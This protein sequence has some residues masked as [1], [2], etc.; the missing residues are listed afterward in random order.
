MEAIRACDT[1]LLLDFRNDAATEQAVVSV[2]VTIYNLASYID[3][4]LNSVLN[5]TFAPIELIVVD[6]CSTDGASV[7]TTLKWMISNRN[8]FCRCVLVQHKHNEGLAQAR[9]TGY[10]FSHSS[11]LFTLDV[12]N[13]IKPLCIETLYSAL[14]GSIFGMAFS[15][16]EIFGDEDGIGTA[17]S[18]DPKRLSKGNYIDAMALIARWA[19]DLVGGYTH[20]EGG[21]EDYDFWCKFVDNDIQGIFVPEMLCRYRVRQDSMLRTKTRDRMAEIKCELIRRHPWLDL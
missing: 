6:D 8:R 1:E 14:N 10:Y 7:S 3:D 11:Y 13:E 9:N 15:Q 12:D 21:W 20:I 4:C 5:Q 2:V 16:L 19:F 17:D 18:W